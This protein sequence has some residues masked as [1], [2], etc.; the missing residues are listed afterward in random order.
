MMSNEVFVSYLVCRRKA[1]FKQAGQSGEMHDFERVQVKLDRCHRHAGLDRFLSHCPNGE[2][3]REPASLA[4]AIQSGAQF[5]VGATAQMGNISSYLD[6]VERLAVG[7]KP[8]YAPVLF[9]HN[10]KVTKLDR[11]LLG[12]QGLA[13][14]HSR[15]GPRCR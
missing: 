5:I 9:L 2:V 1:F 7:E 4:T 6:L 12:F 8:S 15:N 10:H 13:L 3:L 14:A 11:L